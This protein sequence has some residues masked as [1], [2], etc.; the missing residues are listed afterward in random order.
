MRLTAVLILFTTGLLLGQQPEF[1]TPGPTPDGGLL[2]HTGW[3]LRPAGR[4]IRLD[5]FPLATE[6]SPNGKFLLVTH[7]DGSIRVLDT[8]SFDEVHTLKLDH[9]WMGMD[10]TV[11]G[12]LIYVSGGASRNV[13]E[14]EIS[15]R[16]RLRLKRTFPIVRDVEANEYDFV[17]DL[18]LSP[19]GRLIYVALPFRNAVAVI[20]PQSGWVIERYPTARRPYKIV[21][22]PDGKSY[23]VTSWADGSIHHHNA[24]D[25]KQIS[26][27][28]LGPS[29]M[30]MVLH[31]KPLALDEGEELPPWKARIF[32]TVANTNNVRVIGLNESKT[33]RMVETI[34]VN[35]WPWQPL[36]MTPSAVALNADGT[37]LYVV[38]SDANAVA[39]V[40]VS[41]KRSK[42][43]G[44]V[45]AGSYPTDA[46]AVGK[47][48]VVLNGQSDSVQV[49]DH[50][51][52]PELFQYTKTVM[53][54][55]PYS[56]TKMAL[57]AVPPG[58]PVPQGSDVPEEMAS[59][60]KHVVYVIRGSR[61][62]DEVLGD[63]P[64]ANGNPLYTRF[65]KRVTP[66]YHQL[67]TEYVLFDNFY[68]NGETATDGWNWTA[69][70]IAPPFVRRVRG[71]PLNFRREPAAV[72]AAAYLWTNAA[73]AGLSIRNY[74]V[75][76][77][78]D[79]NVMDPLLEPVTRGGYKAFIRDL[80]N[81]S[82]EAEM[83]RLSLIHLDEDDD[84]ALGLIVEACTK[85]NLWERM[86]ILVTELAAAGKDHVNPHRAPAL[87]VSPYTRR[88]GI[89]STMYN[90]A[91]MLRTI[92]LIL[93]LNPLTHFDAAAEPMWRA[94]EP[95]PDLTPYKALAPQ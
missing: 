75:F 8:E 39:V 14:L 91:S 62:Y 47:R 46:A 94:F 19:N 2:L 44:Y 79:G 74:G 10:F 59:P 50:F 42:V 17:G 28:R 58:N 84:Y 49:V 53:R 56:D 51:D 31:D 15:P 72:P 55:S 35:F 77:D 12:N 40:D 83:P 43:L 85:S 25:G 60:I 66:N 5:D 3:T 36:G 18:A 48:L 9:A 86:T 34:K 21:F 76:A 16:G 27:M 70:A 57:P 64:T 29:P 87:I 26:M 23:F 54:N 78:G 71:G 92:E 22:H 24:S 68:T 1:V 52:S 73:T 93:G 95:E 41:G 65:G 13:Y 32:V 89:D 33:M 81:V 61:T 63:I 7:S 4:E 6:L 45:P 20:N 80:V 30:D 11:D 38:C 88:G 37:R 69:A 67:A 82:E 90:T